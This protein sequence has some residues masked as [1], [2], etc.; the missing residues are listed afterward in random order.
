MAA[1]NS[2]APYVP[3]TAMNFLVSVDGFS[4]T[5]A[6]REVTGMDASVDV[7]EFRQG[8]SSSLAPVKIQGLVKHGRVTLKL[9][10]TRDRAFKAWVQSCVSE[11]RGEMPRRNVTIK[12]L[13]T[14]P[15]APQSVQEAAAGTLTWILK[16]AWVTKYS[17]PELD[18]DA[19]EMA[20]EAVELAYEALTIPN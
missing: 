2:S 5:A 9:G 6:F 4:G 16:G 13:H 20:I 10:Y 7:I 8:N 19:V 3:L 15:G 17:G 12:L 14:G 18:T 11:H 1:T